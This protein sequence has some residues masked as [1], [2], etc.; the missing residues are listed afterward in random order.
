ME[1]IPVSFIYKG[2]EYTG[3]LT[4]VSGAAS[5]GGLWH[6][7][8]GGYHWGQVFIEQGRWVCY[9]NSKPELMEVAEDLGQVLIGWYQ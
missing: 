8:V 6:L 3:V 2:R 4:Q 5:A 7:N 1:T 9:S